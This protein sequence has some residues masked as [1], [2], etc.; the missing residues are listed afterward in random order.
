MIQGK[1]HYIYR[2]ETVTPFIKD[3]DDGVYYLYVLNADNKV[4]QASGEF[5]SFKYSQNITDLYPQLDRD[6]EEDNPP[7]AA[8]YAK[9]IPLGEVVTND[10]R[11]V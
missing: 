7:A 1:N 10:L 11:E 3:V 9:R 6:N 5:S 2:V 8:S 4:S